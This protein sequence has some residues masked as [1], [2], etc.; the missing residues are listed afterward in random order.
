M[1][2]NLIVS[3]TFLDRIIILQFIPILAKRRAPRKHIA[4][5]SANLPAISTENPHQQPDTCCHVAQGT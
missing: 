1:F 5:F 2:R 3:L 4:A